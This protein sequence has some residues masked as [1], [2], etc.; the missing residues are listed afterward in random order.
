MKTLLDIEDLQKISDF[1]I[2]NGY[3]D[4]PLTIIIEVLT[5][6]RLKKLNEDL[7]YQYNT[8]KEA[9][10]IDADEIDVNINNFKFKYVLKKDDSENQE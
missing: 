6:E 7:Y 10:I 4:V 9:E 2:E 1:L 8:N 3:G 5:K